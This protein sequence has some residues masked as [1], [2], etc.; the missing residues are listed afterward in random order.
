MLPV[1]CW[2][3]ASSWAS[4]QKDEEPKSINRGLP[5]E[6]DLHSYGHGLVTLDRGL[7]DKVLEILEPVFL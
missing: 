4:I 1:G 7:L 3:N 6:G 5:C 2:N